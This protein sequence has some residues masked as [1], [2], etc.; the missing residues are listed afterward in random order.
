M[1][2]GMFSC[3]SLSSAIAGASDPLEAI[4]RVTGREWV[5]GFLERLPCGRNIA[6]SLVLKLPVSDTPVAIT[7]ASRP[8]QDIT[9]V[10]ARYMGY[11]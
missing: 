1:G 5:K 11:R 7:I 3:C 4:S 10:H 8:T 2:R 9:R 6:Y